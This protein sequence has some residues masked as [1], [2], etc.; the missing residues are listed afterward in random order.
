[1][2]D[3]L[4][5]A[6]TGAVALSGYFQRDPLQF[7]SIGGVVKDILKK[8]TSLVD[9]VIKKTASQIV[10][11][12]LDG[13]VTGGTNQNIFTPTIPNDSISRY[14][15]LDKPLDS[16]PD[17]AQVTPLSF[18]DLVNYVVN[19][20]LAQDDLLVVSQTE[21]LIYHFTAANAGSFEGSEIATFDAEGIQPFE[22]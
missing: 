19:N 22:R 21:G 17:P 15:W 2:S 14:E 12:E 7:S 3:K 1:M 5:L 9:L 13:D 18:A 4:T 11:S 8:E 10:L 6:N 20:E 16:Y